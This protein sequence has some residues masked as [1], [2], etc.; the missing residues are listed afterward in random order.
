MFKKPMV[1][2]LIAF[3]LMVDSGK[4]YGNWTLN[5]G[6]HNPVGATYGV[7]MLYFG[8]KWAFEAG[9]GWARVTKTTTDEQT[10][11]SEG[12]DKEDLSVSFGGDI[13]GKYLFGSGSLRPY[14]QA[15]I[16]AGFG[17][18]VGDHSDAGAGVG[19]LFLGAGLLIG[20]PKLYVYG[21][22]IAGAHTDSDISWQA[23]L[24]FDI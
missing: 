16:G 12:D 7:N 15:G 20:A 23:G 3:V 17:A 13:D 4:A 6:Y 9:L 22:A 5:L 2:A 1:L 14:L 11:A 18:T 24:G 19:G 8:S 21:S 10:T